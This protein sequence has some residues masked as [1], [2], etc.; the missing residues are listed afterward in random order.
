MR[1]LIATA[2][3]VTVPA[4]DRHSSDDITDENVFNG[5]L[6]AD[7]IS[8]ATCQQQN[9][10]LLQCV[11]PP[12]HHDAPIM[13]TAVP[14]RTVIRRLSSGN[15]STQ[16]PLS[17]SAS[18]DGAEGITLSYLSQSQLILRRVD[19][20]VASHVT[21]TDSSPWTPTAVVTSHALRQ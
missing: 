16:F 1:I 10:K 12:I 4:C 15:C 13:D 21:I 19:G 17:V 9:S 7:L 14:L 8:P 5:F 2:L 3:A 6:A 11:I 20:G 18:L